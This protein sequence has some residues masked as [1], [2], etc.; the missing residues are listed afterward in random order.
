MTTGRSWLGFPCTA[1]GG[2]L[3]WVCSTVVAV[4]EIIPVAEVRALTREQAA[5]GRPVMLRGVVTHSGPIKNTMSLSGGF[6]LQDDSGGIWVNVKP[7]AVSEKT[8][9][10]WIGLREPKPGM[11]VEL[12]GVTSPGHYA[13]TIS[14]TRVRYLG[15]AELPKAR[16][17]S[18]PELLVGFGNGQRVELRGVVQHTQE[19]G[20]GPDRLRLEIGALGGRFSMEISDAADLAGIPLVDAEVR[21]TGVCMALFNPRGE[22][23]GVILRSAGSADLRI[24][25]P[26]PADPFA[27]PEAS[28]LALRPFRHGQQ[29]EPLHRQRFSGI[30][31]LSRSGQ[32]LYVQGPQRGFRINT[33]STAT[34]VPGDLVEVAGF[35]GRERGFGVM[36]EAVVRLLPGTNRGVL[37]A[38]LPVTSDRIFNIGSNATELFCEDYD[39]KRVVLH[40]VIASTD[41]LAPDGR[42]ILLN[43]G[44]RLIAADAGQ[45]ERAAFANLRAGSV[46]EAT[47]VCVVQLDAGSAATGVPRPA[48]FS[49]IL[50]DAASIRIL[51][52][53]PWWTPT[54]LWMVI[55]MLL[56]ISSIPIIW[57]VALRHEVARQN[58]IIDEKTKRDVLYEERVRLARELHDTL[59]QHLTGVRMQIE[60]ARN[61]LDE[62]PARARDSLAAAEGMLAFSREEARLAVWSLRHPDLLEDGPAAAI[63]RASFADHPGSPQVSVTESGTPCR[64]PSVIEFHLLRIAQEA[65]TN[66]VK[67]AHA[68]VVEIDFDYSPEAV[69]LAVRDDGRGFHPKPE[70]ELVAAAHFGLIGM[71]ERANKLNGILEINSGTGRGTRISLT[72]PLPYHPPD[73]S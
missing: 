19:E 21:V 57:G 1:L 40:G 50:P 10:E 35:V 66:A 31:T 53:P 72:V 11:L 61:D 64:L 71:R 47:G 44:G 63:R 65:A 17:A 26:P 2:W 70:E 8:D 18:L 33:R 59:E 7:V 22:L 56:G 9:T 49:L 16:A 3:A 14:A 29:A 27:V 60:T 46:V 45:E 37:P 5:E 20:A 6:C 48:G 62:S 54:R 41:P 73:D 55:G 68:G 69:T 23:N 12:Q 38:P 51:R 28:S 30:V 32:F 4:A 34:F 24:E 36:N 43:C 52:A 39:G 67:H 13:P 58:A 25:R 42:Q 15:N